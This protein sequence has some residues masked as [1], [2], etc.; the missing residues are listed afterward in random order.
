M[1]HST[2][3]N[4]N[5]YEDPKTSAVFENLMLLPDN[6]FWHILKTSCY[7]NTDLPKNIGQLQ[8]Y[9]FWP[10]WDPTD[11]M[12]SNF[13]E[14]DLFLRFEDA[15][16]IIEAKYSDLSGQREEQWKN[17]I[18]AYENEYKVCKK[19]IIFIAVGGNYIK[20]AEKIVIRHSTYDISKCT[21]LQLLIATN[22]FLNELEEV[23]FPDY[24]ILATKRIL[25]N[26][27]LAFNINQVYNLEWFNTMERNKLL[28]SQKSLNVLNNE[29]NWYKDY[30]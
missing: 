2:Y 18:I 23:T 8:S 6:V 14:P 11:T 24:N 21:W 7:E 20:S 9:Q 28:I 4:K 1:L 16:I 3:Y 19:K 26:I 29:F 22:K 10:H 5:T 30:E 12:N 13:V 27:I 17:Q 15:D 25:N